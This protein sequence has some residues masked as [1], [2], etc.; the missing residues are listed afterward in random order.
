MADFVSIAQTVSDVLPAAEAAAAVAGDTGL[1]KLGGAIGGGLA[2]IGAGMGIGKLAA[3]AL[4]GTARQPEAADTL[5]GTM[6]LAAA[7]IEGVAL[8]GV[9]VGLLAVVPTRLACLIMA[10]MGHATHRRSTHSCDPSP[11]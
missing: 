5:K 9:V 1:G 7:L 3:A 10:G 8:F 11:C 2:A 4:D 6:I